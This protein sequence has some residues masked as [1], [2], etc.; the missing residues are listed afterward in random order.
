MKASEMRAKSAPEL[1][2]E[3]TEMLRARFALRMQVATQQSNKTSEIGRIK[4][5][6]ARLRTV[7]H[8]KARAQ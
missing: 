1:K 4:R 3:L 7:L 6:I 8:E 5:E 2:S